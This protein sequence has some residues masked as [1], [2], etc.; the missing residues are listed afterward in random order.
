[1]K[2]FITSLNFCGEYSDHLGILAVITGEMNEELDSNLLLSSKEKITFEKCISK[3]RQLRFFRGRAAGKRAII[4][5]L[6]E[7]LDPKTVSICNGVFCQPYVADQSLSITISHTEKTSIALVSHS[8]QLVGI[9]IELLERAEEASIEY[10]WPERKFID[11]EDGYLLEKAIVWVA[12]ESLSKALGTGLTAELEIFIPKKI[13]GC[14]SRYVCYFSHF[15]H[16]RV[17]IFVGTKVIFSIAFCNS[18]KL[19]LDSQNLLST[20][21][22]WCRGEELFED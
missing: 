17:E 11:G 3:N 2:E 18:L 5:Y 13:Q 21:D 6:K 9:D 16:F 20:L 15:P 1:M 22:K 10:W 7:D 8:S 12:M 4:S 19:A 14:G